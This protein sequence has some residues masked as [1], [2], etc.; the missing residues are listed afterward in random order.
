MIEL[1]PARYSEEAILEQARK[2]VKFGNPNCL[3]CSESRWDLGNVDAEAVE[4]AC[5]KLWLHP[6]FR[7]RQTH[8][9]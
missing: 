8:E 5:G 6:S 9:G 1:P 3:L 7:Y 4:I 2:L